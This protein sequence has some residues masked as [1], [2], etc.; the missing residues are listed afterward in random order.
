MYDDDDDVSSTRG[1]RASLR[2]D[3]H[4]KSKDDV[5]GDRRLSVYSC[6]FGHDRRRRGSQKRNK[7]K[8]KKRKPKPK[9]KLLSW[10]GGGETT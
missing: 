8:N 7:N 5:V 9:P 1:E 6:H 2:L 10:S 3:T 4:P